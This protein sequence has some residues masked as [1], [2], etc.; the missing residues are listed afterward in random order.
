MTKARYVKADKI[1][2]KAVNESQFKNKI[3]TLLKVYCSISWHAHRQGLSEPRDL[4]A[5]DRKAKDHEDQGFIKARKR[6]CN[7]YTALLIV[8]LSGR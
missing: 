5:R 6:Q 7:C 1:L 8:Y 2:Q 3:E 4:G